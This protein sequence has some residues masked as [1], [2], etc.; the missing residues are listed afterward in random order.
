MRADIKQQLEQELD[1]LFAVYR[2]SFHDIEPSTQFLAGVWRKIE[3]RRP[4]D[5]L[6]LVLI[7]SPRLAMA[8]AL[9]AGMLTLAVWLPERA[10]RAAA[11]LEGG[12][13]EALTV[14][15][16]DADEAAMWSLAGLEMQANRD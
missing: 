15:T 12:Y 9:A 6:T 8:S 2:R 10:A 7:W 14:E 16:L 13:I 1:R 4:L 11:V 3:A 5:W